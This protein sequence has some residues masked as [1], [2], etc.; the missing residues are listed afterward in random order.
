MKAMIIDKADIRLAV[1]DLEL[2]GDRL[3]GSGAITVTI[4]TPGIPHRLLLLED[5]GR[6]IAEGEFGKDISLSKLHHFEGDQIT[7]R[8]ELR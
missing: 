6:V 5:W 8:L 1:E 7:I 4:T 3:L 2:D